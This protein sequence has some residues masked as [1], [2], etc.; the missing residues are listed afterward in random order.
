METGMTNLKHLD[1]LHIPC[2]ADGTTSFGCDQEWFG[3]QWQRRAGCGP[4]VATNLL[5]YLAADGRIQ[6]PFDLKN[7]MGCVD[8]MD[9]V[10]HHVTPTMMGVNTTIR[11]TTGMRN[12]AF[13]HRL[14]MHCAMLDVPKSRRKRPNT[15][16]IVDF[17]RAGLEMDCPVAF[18]NLHNG[19]VPLLDSWHWVTLISLD[20]DA[21]AGTAIATAY[22]GDKEIPVDLVHWSTHTNMGGGFVRLDQ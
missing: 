13:Q 22:D 21:T 15:R 16:E 18:L 4:N 2:E 20:V 8:L 19:D 1:T 17:V 14:P 10:W 12:F 3:T 5:M 9:A 7:R 11:F 6:L